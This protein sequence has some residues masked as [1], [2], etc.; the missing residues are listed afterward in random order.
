MSK[1]N[2]F[3]LVGRRF[4]LFLLND[5]NIPVFGKDGTKKPIPFG[6]GFL[7]ILKVVYSATSSI[8]LMF[9]STRMRPQYSQTIIF[10]RLAMS[11]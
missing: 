7:H 3:P 10:L 11:S 6:T 2:R 9:S 1:Q 5:S 4:F 8:T